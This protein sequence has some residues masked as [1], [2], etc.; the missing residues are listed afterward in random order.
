MTTPK[1]NNPSEGGMDGEMEDFKAWWK[2]C[3]HGGVSYEIAWLARA[4]SIPHDSG[5]LGELEK[6]A[7]DFQQLA[8]VA[9]RSDGSAMRR[10]IWSDASYRLQQL[11]AKHR[12][13]S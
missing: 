8:D 10:E 13:K 3:K 9:W 7:D 11:I 5:L 4:Q 12:G 1:Q 2:T 6:L